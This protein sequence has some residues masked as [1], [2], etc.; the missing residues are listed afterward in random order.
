MFGKVK[1]SLGKWLRTIRPL[2]NLFR[3]P[4]KGHCLR[5]GVPYSPAS[6]VTLKSQKHHLGTC[7]SSKVPQGGSTSPRP[8]RVAWATRALEKVVSWVVAS[9]GMCQEKEPRAHI[10]GRPVPNLAS[11]FC[12]WVLRPLIQLL[13][14]S[15]LLT[16]DEAGSGR[17]GVK[18]IV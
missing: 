18:R 16:K 17:W 2:L 7:S 12:V 1:L 8:A 11:A 9:S 5:V 10:F 3:W 14:G 13:R 6:L 15:A 4:A